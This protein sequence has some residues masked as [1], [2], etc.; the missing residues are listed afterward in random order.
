MKQ[1][2]RDEKWNDSERKF[3]KLLES[4]NEILQLFDTMTFK[5]ELDKLEKLTLSTGGKNG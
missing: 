2:W 3:L 5:Q 4:R 1:D